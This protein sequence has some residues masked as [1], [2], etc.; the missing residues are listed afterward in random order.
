VRRCRAILCALLVVA[1]LLPLAWAA[2]PPPLFYAVISDTQKGD[3]DPF[4]EFAWAIE[5]VNELRP[6]FVLM[7][8]DLTNTGTDNQYMNFMEVA[9]RCQV[10]IYYCV[11]NHGAVP[12]ED[13]YRG[14]FTHYTG[15]PTWYHR[16]L[17]GWHLFALDSARFVEGKLQHDG[18]I[19]LEE[20]DWLSA[21]LA[22]M[23]PC[24]PVFL[25]E[26]HPL[27]VKPDG[28]QNAAELLELFR[29]RYLAY[30]VAGHF[31]RNGHDVDDR[32][33]HH[34]ITGSLSFSTRPAECGIGYRLI[35]TVGTDLWTAWV[36][37]DEEL[38]LAPW[39]EV[40]G[41]GPLH[42]KWRTDLPG[43]APDD[44]GLAVGVRYSGDGLRVRFGVGP[45]VELPPTRPAATA[46]VILSS[47]Q[48]RRIARAKTPAVW[49]RPLGEARLERVA[50]FH[51]SAD[52][53]HYGLRE[54]CQ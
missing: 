24:Q 28:L 43:D 18:E 6:E 46:L 20:L 17:G 25:A 10:P 8:G 9:E 1:A 11:G 12:G 4:A 39:Y 5:Q 36:E 15:Q 40:D 32:G 22:R 33:V 31:H 2:E 52:W 48:S 19:G 41:P 38:P 47:V 23:G 53:E 44:G 54:P 45:P 34:F 27:S 42:G 7:P 3:D 51:T 16:K 49:I 30:T 50:L 13:G 35:S 21:Q 29:N 14:R 37:T 26:H